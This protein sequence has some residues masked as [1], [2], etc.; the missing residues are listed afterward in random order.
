MKRRGFR[1]EKGVLRLFLYEVVA[2]V[3]FFISFPEKKRSKD[4]IAG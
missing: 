1:R 4:N 2:E 3:G